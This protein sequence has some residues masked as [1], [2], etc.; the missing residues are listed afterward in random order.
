VLGTCHRVHAPAS[1]SRWHAGAARYNLCRGHSFQTL[2]R[3][4][5]TRYLLKSVMILPW[6]Q[7]THLEAHWVYIAECTSILR[8]TLGL[9]TRKVRLCSDDET[10]IG[11]P[12]GL[13][14]TWPCSSTIPACGCGKSFIDRP[15]S[16]GSVSTASSNTPKVSITS[17][18]CQ[19]PTVRRPSSVLLSWIE[20][21]DNS[22]I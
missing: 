5:P 21:K 18:R 17:R 9:V 2:K 8:D 12:G 14:A 1:H 20:Q 10:L 11:G 22:N 15:T 3:V 6:A 7:L 19:R 4:I 13:S 16:S